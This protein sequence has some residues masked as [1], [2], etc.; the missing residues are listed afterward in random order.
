MVCTRADD[1]HRNDVSTPPPACRAG[2]PNWSLAGR[3]ARWLGQA[4][5]LLRGHGGPIKEVTG[6]GH[7]CDPLQI[8]N[9]NP[10]GLGPG[11]RERG[12]AWIE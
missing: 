6:L 8:V 12:Q 2:T 11:G 9:G 10:P 1:A 4:A 5:G 3:V 7:G